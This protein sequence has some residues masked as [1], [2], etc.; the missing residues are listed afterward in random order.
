MNRML[1]LKTY[2]QL[3]IHNLARAFLYR[4]SLRLGWHPVTRL[5]SQPLGDH[6]FSSP[7]PPYTNLTSS[8]AW[9]ISS[10]F[11]GYKSYP[12]S[13]TPP[14]WHSNIFN[15]K[16]IRADLQWWKIP[17]FNP[18][19]G[20]I[21]TIWEPSRFDW[22]LNM[23]QRAAQGENS[24][25]SRMNNW[26]TD[27][28]I[29]NPTYFGPNWKCGQESSIRVIHLALASHF[30]GQD[31]SPEKDLTRLVE[32]HLARIRPT[33]S[34]AIAQD[35]NH[36]TS[37]GAALFIGGSMCETQGLAQAKH[38]S[39]TGRD[40]LENR[41]KRLIAKDGSFSQ[42]SLNYHRLMLDTLSV[43]ELWRRWYNLPPFS[44]EY[45]RKARAATSWLYQMVDPQS[46]DVPNI[47]DND[48]AN[49]LPLTNADY[50]DFRPSVQLAM[51][52][53]ENQLAYSEKGFHDT[54]LQWLE[55]QSPLD[56]TPPPTSIDFS[57]GGYSILR[58]HQWT[59]FLKYPKYNFRPRHCDALHLDL[60]HGSKNILSD[61]GSYSYNTTAPWQE[62]F[63]GTEAHNTISF[64]KRDQM[65]SL[66]RF[67]RGSW[68]KTTNQ[69]FQDSNNGQTLARAGYTDWQGAHH[70]RQITLNQSGIEIQDRISGFKNQA[71]LRWHLHPGI[72]KLSKNGV[73]G[74]GFSLEILSEL[75][76]V[77]MELVQGWQSRYY[78]EKTET[79]VLEVEFRKPGIIITRIKR[80]A[81]D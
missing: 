39:Q 32:V 73:I 26:L 14:L 74:H 33:I 7:I 40:L 16:T 50:R 77:R 11:F 61:A 10:L 25:I 79:P 1:K 31:S 49:L 48:G 70:G 58:Q 59:A 72:W 45:M 65:P 29:N 13:A 28:C 67:L 6:F 80:T 66:G 35:N 34:Y 37:E 36:G 60:W 44:T 76:I 75:E 78:L 62:Y 5:D 63:P 2:L 41:V 43:V 18:S 64:D 15:K 4:I 3:G 21:K 19:V 22:V 57:D 69:K 20:D 17:D 27:W 47:G 53:F 24:E 38:W 71:V 9:K 30:L 55:V 68:L 23:A 12:I 81:E 46:G 8:S 51:A 54:H 56:K 42:H 52:L